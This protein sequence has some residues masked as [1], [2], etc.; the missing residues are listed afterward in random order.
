M[1]EDRER[2][3]V[4]GWLGMC[5]RSHPCP[6]GCHRTRGAFKPS[7]GT[8]PWS[9]PGTAPPF[10]AEP[11]PGSGGTRGALSEAAAAPWVQGWAPG[12]VPAQVG[13]RASLPQLLTGVSPSSAHFERDGAGSA[14]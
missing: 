3:N 12:S 4:L 13:L 8:G 11:S 5:Q 9:I 7:L 14:R 2:Q 1:L 10:W 6:P